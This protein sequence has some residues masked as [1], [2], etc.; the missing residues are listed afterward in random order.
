MVKKV[1][2]FLLFVCGIIAQDCPEF[3]TTTIEHH[4]VPKTVSLPAFKNVKTS[5]VSGLHSIF[6]LKI[7]W[8][9][10]WTPQLRECYE[11]HYGYPPDPTRYSMYRSS[12][13][14]GQEAYTAI[15]GSPVN[16][17]SYLD[18]PPY[19][20]V[21]TYAV[22]A[23]SEP[24]S[25]WDHWS[26]RT[27]ST[28]E[29]VSTEITVPKV[30]WMWGHWTGYSIRLF[31]VQPPE[32][33]EYVIYRGV[34]QFWVDDYVTISS[35]VAALDTFGWNIY[36]QYFDYDVEEGHMYFYDIAA[37]I[38]GV[39]GPRHGLVPFDTFELGVKPEYPPIN[40]LEPEEE[41]GGGGW[42]LFR[43]CSAP[44]RSEEK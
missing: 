30:E 13:E 6:V 2:L 38:S 41:G 22:M 40:E 35:T 27:H 20:G 5:L 4:G 26:P 24:P 7:S 14:F 21:W 29:M 44:T 12:G 16:D 10:Y 31:W 37:K 39:V 34:D 1:V 9:Y 28:I 19:A 3:G 33:D 32:A 8:D 43:S 11:A 18:T 17:T 36:G 23:K 42:F 25:G 15:G